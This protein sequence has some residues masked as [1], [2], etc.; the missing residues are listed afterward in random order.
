VP[1]LAVHLALR[2]PLGAQGSSAQGIAAPR[3]I[4]VDGHIPLHARGDESCSLVLF[5]S[6]RRGGKPTVAVRIGGCFQ[7]AA[8]L[9]LEKNI[10]CRSNSIKK[11]T[12]KRK[13]EYRSKVNKPKN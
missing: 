8:S 9:D 2:L 6:K 4:F 3:G 5:G 12:K 11:E 1:K 10:L 7:F 13:R